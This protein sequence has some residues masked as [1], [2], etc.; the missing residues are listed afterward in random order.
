MSIKDALLA[1]IGSEEDGIQGRTLLQ[2]KMY[3]LSVL[4]KENFRFTPYYYG[5]YSS[6]VADRLGALKEAAFV[7]EHPERYDASGPFGE[8]RR[9]DYRLTPA[10]KQVVDR[11]SEDLKV[12]TE[13]LEE[14]NDHPIAKDTRLLSVAAKVH[15]IVSEHGRATVEKVQQRAKELGW[16]VS[17]AE[18]DQVVNYLK[19]LD[20]VATRPDQS[21]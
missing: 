12:Y 21:P 16:K 20:L 14:I 10:G 3:F 17:T 1:A 13:A 15:F 19:H 6:M 4:I 18:I 8:L 7:S 9:F 2:K 11:N 5:P